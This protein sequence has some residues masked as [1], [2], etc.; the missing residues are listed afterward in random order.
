[1]TGLPEGCSGLYDHICEKCN[2]AFRDD[3]FYD[4]FEVVLCDDCMTN[5]EW[6]EESR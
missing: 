5:Q 4:E 1:M 2:V 6:T 3:R